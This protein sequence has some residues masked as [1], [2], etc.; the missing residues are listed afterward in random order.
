MKG[1]II[2]N[3]TIAL[4]LN[5]LETISAGTAAEL[6]EDSRFFNTLNG[7]TDRY[8]TMKILFGGTSKVDEIQHT[9]ANAG[10][11][12]EADYITGNTYSINAKEVSQQ[13]AREFAMLG[14]SK[15]L[16]QSDWDW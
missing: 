3:T 16:T 12:L 9:W 4:N 10:V 13:E 7:A 6:A 5:E 2:M 15:K 8:G 1:I 11:R 14:K